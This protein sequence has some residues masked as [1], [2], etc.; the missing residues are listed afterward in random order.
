MIYFDNSASSYYKPKCVINAVKNALEYMPANPGR[1]GH[2]EALKGAFLVTKTRER[3]A[4]FVGLNNRG[5]VVFTDNCTGAINL[6]VLGAA[7]KGNVVTTAFE[8]N[9]VLRCLYALRRSGLITLTVVKP[10]S[11]G[12]LCCKTLKNAL[13][14]DT[15]MVIVNHISNLTGAVAPIA[16]IG[17][18][19]RRRGIIFAVDGAQSVGYEGIDMEGSNIDLLAV[20]PH[21]GL[22]AIQGVGALCVREGVAL[23]PVRF[24]GTGSSSTQLT[25]PTDMPEGYE[26]GTLPLPAISGLCA[27]IG[28]SKENFAKNADKLFHLRRYLLDGV[29][30][31]RGARVY[32]PDG[33]GA[34][35]VAFNLDGMSSETVGDELNSRYGICV[36]S[37][38]H[39]APLIHEHLGT[40]K[41]G[42]VRVSLGVDN[43]EEQVEYLINA[44]RE[45][46]EGFY[47][48]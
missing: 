1:S 24:G 23:S 31:V 22:H 32:T 18:E 14:A 35:I 48:R 46:S 47:H 40:L 45:I 7:K 20:A 44:L 41:T 12:T 15:Y 8:H 17:E 30:S 33:G 29:K 11:R 25:Q 28:W 36:R 13:S 3:L 38:L 6:A 43:D 39:C 21:K 16:E 19:C 37:G 5:S 26:A 42:A 10:E 2:A 9:S 4:D 34:G 27:A